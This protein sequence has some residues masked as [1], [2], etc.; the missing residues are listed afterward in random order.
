MGTAASKEPVKIDKPVVQA[1]PRPPVPKARTVPT[2]KPKVVNGHTSKLKSSTRKT[3]TR[4]SS[5]GKSDGAGSAPSTPPSKWRLLTVRHA[6]RLENWHVNALSLTPAEV[7]RTQSL[8]PWMQTEWRD[9]PRMPKFAEGRMFSSERV[10]PN[11]VGPAFTSENCNKLAA[12]GGPQAFTWDGQGEVGQMGHVIQ[13][14]GVVFFTHLRRTSGTFLEDC[15][16]KPAL[17]F[18]LGKPIPDLLK[19]GIVVNCGEG[20]LGRFGSSAMLVEQRKEVEEKLALSLAVYRHCPHGLHSFT[21]RPHTYIT[22]LREPVQRMLSW[23]QMCIHLS[24]TKCGMQPDPHLCVRLG[25]VARC[26]FN[27]SQVKAHRISPETAFYT[28]RENALANQPRSKSLPRVDLNQTFLPQRLEFLLDDNYMVRMLCGGL[29]HEQEGQVGGSELRCAQRSLANHYSFIGL[30]EHAEESMCLLGKQLG[31]R[32]HDFK[33]EDRKV[34]GYAPPLDFELAHGKKYAMD[35]ELYRFA[36]AQFEKQLDLHP[37]CTARPRR[38]GPP[39]PPP[40]PWSSFFAAKPATVPRARQAQHRE[41]LLRPPPP[42]P[43]PW[44][45]MPPPMPLANHFNG[46]NSAEQVAALF[47]PSFR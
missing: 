9:Q 17:A 22:Y 1:K 15:Y 10:L 32:P 16:V 38:A 34:H 42:P 29:V 2:A 26:T 18:I 21:H 14:R 33:Y 46:T 43:P 25:G 23:A 37:E 4:G 7:S 47:R 41:S 27:I 6:G 19:H 20:G 40:P 30:L 24:N 28:A 31:L 45:P 13:Q 36:V 8:A 35:V 39:P 12:K 44:S 5:R 3:P 11:G